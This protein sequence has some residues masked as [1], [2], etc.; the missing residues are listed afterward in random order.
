MLCAIHGKKMVASIKSI[1]FIPFY[2]MGY[3][4]FFIHPLIF[5]LFLYNKKTKLTVCCVVTAQ[6]S[7]YL[8][9][10]LRKY[11]IIIR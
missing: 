4:D 6:P 8:F 7:N 3:S 1:Y 9:F 11:S 5:Y 10:S 2:I